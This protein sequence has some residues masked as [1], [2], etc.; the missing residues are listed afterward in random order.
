MRRVACHHGDRRV[1]MYMY[2]PSFL[3]VPGITIGWPRTK[4]TAKNE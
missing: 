3:G 2:M 4:G 1:Y